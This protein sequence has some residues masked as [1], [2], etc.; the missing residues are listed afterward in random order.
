MLI[1]S[2]VQE[3]VCHRTRNNGEILLYIVLIASY[4]VEGAIVDLHVGGVMKH[5]SR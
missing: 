4:I 5:G 2:A 1:M 3:E